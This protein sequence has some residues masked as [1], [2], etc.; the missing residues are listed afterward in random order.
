MEKKTAKKIIGIITFSLL[1]GL[2]FVAY[3]GEWPVLA[4]FFVGF[5]IG[6]I[7]MFIGLNL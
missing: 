4:T 1:I 3:A 5:P 7:G 2:G 6:T